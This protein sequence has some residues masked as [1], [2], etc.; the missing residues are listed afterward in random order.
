[1]RRTPIRILLVV[2]GLTVV[3]LAAT[4]ANCRQSTDTSTNDGATASTARHD[5]GVDREDTST[6]E[7][8]TPA[9]EE[10]TVDPLAKHEWTHRPVVIFATSRDEPVYERQVAML[11]AHAD[12][13]RERD[14]VVYHVIEEGESVG[15][16]GAVSEGV[17]RALRERA[18]PETSFLV[19]LVGKDGTEK[20][21]RT[22]MLS[23]ET[24]FETI[25]AMPMR[26]REMREQE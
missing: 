15:P 20:L 13:L 18:E 16:S 2:A 11:E 3:W 25:D 24:L 12:G 10:A 21:R 8:T 19:V 9:D 6:S 14:I 4:G 17:A 26:R 1:M 5:D 22:E 23:A 7:T